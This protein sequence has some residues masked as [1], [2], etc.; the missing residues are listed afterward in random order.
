MT[1]ILLIQFKLYLQRE[2]DPSSNV[3]SFLSFKAPLAVVGHGR[4]GGDVPRFRCLPSSVKSCPPAALSCLVLNWTR[5][6]HDP[7][8]NPGFRIGWHNV[9]HA[10]AAILDSDQISR[11]HFDISFCFRS[12]VPNGH[13]GTKS[14]MQCWQSRCP[15][16]LT[17]CGR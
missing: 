3:E 16:P 4:V 1:T 12:V 13:E 7:A 5:I 14:Q 2:K 10:V 9:H 15:Q 17:P 8:D 11:S 6:Q